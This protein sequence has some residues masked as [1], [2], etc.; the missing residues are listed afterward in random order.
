MA[1]RKVARGTEFSGLRILVCNDDG[2]DSPGLKVLERVAKSL[3]PD[4][5]VV[6][7]QTEQSAVSHSL[8]LSVPLR[9][10]RLSRRRFAVEGTPTDCVVMALTHV[11]TGQRPT[12]L[13]A[14]VNRGANLGEDVTYSG[15]IAAA[16]EG[17]LLG[18]PSIAL[19]QVFRYPEPVKWATA[20]YHAPDL[21]R[22]LLRAGWPKK[23]LINVNFPNLVAT[24]V[25][26]FEVTSQGWRD[27]S[28]LRTD[29]RLDVRG[30][31]Y[32]W[33]GFRHHFGAP[34][35]GTDR[36]AI[37]A[38]SVSVTPLQLDLTHGAARKALRVALQ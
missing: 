6:A 35:P 29:E 21:L 13:L 18:V 19:S 38:G 30:V 11:I 25:N 15:T 5:W 9:V 7:P 27:V 22:K 4:V 31:P 32:Y 28:D 17:T 34:R 23:V 36:A 33:I 12:L 1:R 20:E 8:T 26:G 14:G 3:T 24:K 10:R 2:I 16:M 37:A